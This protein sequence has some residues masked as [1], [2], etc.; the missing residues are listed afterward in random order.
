[1]DRTDTEVSAKVEWPLRPRPCVGSAGM[2]AWD[3][4]RH[5]ASDANPAT[6]AAALAM[7]MV[8]LAMLNKKVF[9]DRSARNEKDRGARR[10]G[11]RKLYS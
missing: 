1:M 4:G 6:A 8:A 2:K 7:V 10:E 9:D 11:R 3:D 5:A